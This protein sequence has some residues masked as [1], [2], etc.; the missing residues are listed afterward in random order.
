M[1]REDANFYEF[2]PFRIDAA[3]RLLLRGE[4]VISLTPK[5]FDT[6]LLL[7][8]N[9]GHVLEKDEMIQALWP[10][11]FVEEGNLTQNISRLRKVLSVEEGDEYIKTLP[12][13]GYRFE[14]DVREVEPESIDLIMRRKRTRARIT[15]TEETLDTDEPQTSAQTLALPETSL[16]T[17]SMA[18][19]PFMTLGMG[20]ESEY[21]GL[22]LADALITQLGSTQQ[23][24]VR[25]TSAVRQYVDARQDSAQIGRDLRVGAVLEGSLQRAGERL[26]ITV[27]LVSVRDDAPLWAEKFNIAFTDIFEMQ[28]TIA[29]QVSAALM[30]KLNEAE[31]ERMTRRY[32]ENAEA[33]QAYLKGRYFWNKRTLEGYQK[34]LEHFNL[35]IEHDPTYALAYVGLADTYNILPVWGEVSSRES[36]PRAK[37]AARRA[38]ELDETLAEAHASLGYAIAH[39]DWDWAEA[40]RAY[41]RALELKP[42]YATAHQWYAKL[43]VAL[44]R[45][46]EANA[47]MR[48]AQNQDPLS[49]IVN[50]AVGGP[51]YYSRQYDAAIE[52]FR[53][54]LDLDPNF[55]PALYSLGRAYLCK[56]MYDEAIAAHRKV[57]E[58]SDEH[59]FSLAGLSAT[60][61]AAGRREEAQSLLDRLLEISK[62]RHVLTFGLAIIYASLNN[63]DEAFRWLEIAYEERSGHLADL[64]IEPF[65]DHLRTDPRFTDLL[66]RLGLS[67]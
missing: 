34:A 30:L 12:R 29:E 2:G 25:P 16:A 3:E 60:Y 4:E 65:F 58:L 50:T 63:V 61:A 54:V 49:L 31:R 33:Y 19:L 20:T 9:N 39:Y 47:E 6:L 46:D 11:T 18:V 45:F 22:G 42:N 5:V 27:Q 17:K 32:T 43:L 36:L 28:D 8:E 64:N 38:L 66:S 15:I 24:V 56:Q 48:Q 1:N 40:E 37:A 57:L 26:R 55:I 13:R 44:E 67:P 59:P 53:K 62:Q 52:Q 7:V 35:A 23:M 51:Y 10:D 14:A 41:R 21:L